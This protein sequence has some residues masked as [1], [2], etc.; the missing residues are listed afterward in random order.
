MKERIIHVESYW[1]KGGT[2]IMKQFYN[3][4]PTV[5]PVGAGLKAGFLLIKFWILS[6]KSFNYKVRTKGDFTEVNIC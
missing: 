5:I 6:L 1:R 2:S 3:L 4:I